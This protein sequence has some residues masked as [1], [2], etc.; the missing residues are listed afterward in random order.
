MSS[1]AGV[2]L[3]ARLHSHFGVCFKPRLQHLCQSTLKPTRWWTS[4]RTRLRL[5]SGRLATRC[6]PLPRAATALA[7]TSHACNAHVPCARLQIKVMDFIP[8]KVPAAQAVQ[9]AALLFENVPASHASQL[10]A[11]PVECLPASQSVHEDD[12]LPL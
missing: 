8:L 6:H 5:E 12:E 10:E 2:C 3:P 9:E 7:S 4:L 1:A 11:P